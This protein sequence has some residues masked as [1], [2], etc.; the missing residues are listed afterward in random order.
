MNKNYYTLPRDYFKDLFDKVFNI[1]SRDGNV[2]VSAL[3][4]GGGKTFFN[5]FLEKVNGL[6]FFKSIQYYDPD[7]EKVNILDYV[8]K[9][10]PDQGKNLFIIRLFEQ[11]E[12]KQEVLENL[13][14]I[15]K[16]HPG[17]LVYL[18]FSDHTM[19]TNPQDYTGKTTAFFLD[20]FYISPYDFSRSKTMIK[21]NCD[22]YGWDVDASLHK[23]I[24]ELSGGIPRLCKYVA[25]EID[26]DPKKRINIQRILQNPN[27]QFQLKYLNDLLFRCSK[28]QLEDLGLLDNTGKIKS[29]LL[30]T[31]F[32]KYQNTTLVQLFP[33]LSVLERQLLTLL[34]EQKELVVSL[35]KIGDMFEIAG[36]EFSPWAIYKLISRL[37]PKVSKLFQI[38][39]I[40]GQGY[41]LR[42]LQ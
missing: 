41:L 6:N 42:S 10:T 18:I 28:I 14:M 34:Y 19:L 1:L 21:I 23:M 2:C 13:E 17:K 7:I 30:R 16:L 12:G 3:I 25:K 36:R 22:F 40:K 11:I 20:R 8:K 32:Q 33:K 39:S 24:F 31:Y 35:D 4:G 9:N 15:K 27:V 38:E 26:E 29:S 37:K 5:Y